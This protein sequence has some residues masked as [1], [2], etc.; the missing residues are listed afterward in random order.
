MK[1]MLQYAADHSAEFKMDYGNIPQQSASTIIRA[2]VAL[3]AEGAD[4]R[5]SRR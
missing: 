4:R 5:V 2:I 1:A 3:E